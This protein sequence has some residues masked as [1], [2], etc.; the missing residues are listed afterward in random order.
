MLQGPL[1]L[2]GGEVLLE[3][4]TER[5]EEIDERV[6]D[7]VLIVR[8]GVE[9]VV[10]ALVD[11]E[12]L[13]ARCQMEAL[14]FRRD[15]VQVHQVAF[16]FARTWRRIEASECQLLQTHW[17]LD[18]GSIQMQWHDGHIFSQRWVIAI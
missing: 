9:R 18:F 17:Q 10:S 15:R 4:R 6:V 14:V 2:N 12:A 8:P 5:V 13:C 16:H 11:E 7:P 1:A 3:D